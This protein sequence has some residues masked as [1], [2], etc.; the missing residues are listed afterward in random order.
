MLQSGQYHLRLEQFLNLR[1]GKVA[2]TDRANLSL[3]YE[4]FHRCPRV[5]DRYINH[6]DEACL[7]IDRLDGFI[8]MLKRDRPVYL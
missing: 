8:G 7:G 2:Y 3:L 5:L 4:P 1:L 6:V